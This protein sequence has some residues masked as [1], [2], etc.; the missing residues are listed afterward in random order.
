[1]RVM[2]SRPK[3]AALEAARERLEEA[4]HAFVD[5]C[6]EIVSRIDLAPAE[7]ALA[8]W[9][10]ASEAF[11]EEAQ[12]V[13]DE[14]CAYFDDRSEKWQD[15]ETGLAFATWRDELE[16]LADFDGEPTD[17]VRLA[18]DLSDETP[19][20]ELEGDPSDALPELPDIPALEA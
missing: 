3:T 20:V 17:M 10:K 16:Q 1:M 8:T 19:V 14:A 9:R 12:R 2:A 11:T 6:A 7:E 5:V 4:R 13:Y 18:I 15:S